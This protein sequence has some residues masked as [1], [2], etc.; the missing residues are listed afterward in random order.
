[1][2]WKIILFVLNRFPSI[3]SLLCQV[4]LCCVVMTFVG[5]DEQSIE[6]KAKK[7]FRLLNLVVVVDVEYQASA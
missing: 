2:E 4:G 1:M 7:G 3:S 5:L 6:N